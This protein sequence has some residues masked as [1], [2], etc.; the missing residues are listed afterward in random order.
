MKKNLLISIILCLILLTACGTTENNSDKNVDK[1]TLKCTKT[2]YDEDG[3]KTTDEMIV[4]YKKD[5]VTSVLETNVSEI[6]PSVIDMTLSFGNLFAEKLSEIDGLNVEYTKV[7]EKTLQFTINVDYSKVE[8]DKVKQV[9]GDAYD[10]KQS[11]MYTKNIEL[12]TFKKDI[13]SNYTCE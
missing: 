8:L 2:E 9:F 5:I 10:E 1:G 3:Y 13:L 4:T 7:N 12:D 6:D 11:S